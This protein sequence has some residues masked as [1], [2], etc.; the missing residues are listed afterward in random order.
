MKNN[1][2]SSGGMGLLSVLTVVFVVLRLVHV[3]DWS[4][5]WVLSPSII[6]VVIGV[7]VGIVL[8]VKG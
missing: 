4:W 7:V 8:V 2:S 6:S 3:I 5:W 1:Q